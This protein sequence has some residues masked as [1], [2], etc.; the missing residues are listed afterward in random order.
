MNYNIFTKLSASTNIVPDASNL[1]AYI[2]TEE[3]MEGK[4]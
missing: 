1:Q 4:V 2:P 3:R